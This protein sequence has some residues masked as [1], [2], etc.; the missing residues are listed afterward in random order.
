MSAMSGRVF[1]IPKLPASHTLPRL[2]LLVPQ[3]RHSGDGNGASEIIGRELCGL[4]S[5]VFERVID[6]LE[7]RNEG[8]G[9]GV[10]RWI[11]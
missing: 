7:N 3:G 10:H 9:R 6:T 11:G 5:C 2:H 8:P 1:F 4:Q